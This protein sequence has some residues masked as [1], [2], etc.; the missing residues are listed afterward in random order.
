MQRQHALDDIKTEGM[1]SRPCLAVDTQMRGSG[2]SLSQFQLSCTH[3]GQEQAV[4]LTSLDLCT[5]LSV[6]RTCGWS[7]CAVRVASGAGPLDPDLSM[8]CRHAQACLV[9]WDA[10]HHKAWTT[11]SQRLSVANGVQQSSSSWWVCLP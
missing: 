1:Q 2:S 11:Y 9:T 5:H 10:S 3:A 4:L 6:L 8:I 7:R